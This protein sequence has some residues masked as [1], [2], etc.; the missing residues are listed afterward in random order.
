MG[1]SPHT[2][3]EGR[4]ALSHPHGIGVAMS[5]HLTLRRWLASNFDSSTHSSNERKKGEYTPP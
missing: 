2:Q 4:L 5:H 1:E 3:I